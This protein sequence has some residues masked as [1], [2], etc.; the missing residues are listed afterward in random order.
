MTELSP[1]CLDTRLLDEFQRDLPLVPRP[2]AAM[3][4]VLGTTEDDVLERLERLQDCGRISRVGATCRPN[5]AGAS[6][7][8]ALAIPETRIEEVA[9]VVG[10][11][12]GVNHS[13]LREDRWNLWFVA[14]APSEDELSA[15]LA[16]IEAGTGL[17]VLSLP[18]VRPFNI[19]LGFRLRGP[20]QPL[21]L[22]RAPDMKALHEDDRP[23]MQALS[24]G[25]DLVPAPFAALAE[26]LDRNEAE[27]IAR[28]GALAQAR[29][30]TRVGVIVRHRA[31]GWAANAMVV[32]QLP[33][34]AIEAAG[35]A[36]AQVPGVT[37][38]YQ[39]RLVPGVWDWP[40]FCMI[41]ARSREEALE[42]LDRAR[43][44]PELAEVPHKILFSTRCFK[45]RGALIEAA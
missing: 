20:R 8:A 26:R 10:A 1:D 45:Q 36:L 18:L 38:C 13:Y 37:L 33:E 34:P 32:W 12:P 27:V 25:L 23:L 24:K 4:E 43:T 11:E 7:L 17:T 31:L 39:R 6:T 2:F 42:V 5:T 35:R 41:H 29:I 9:A 44:L 3:A 15:S 28:I 22:D 14:T 30:L 16:R 21:G 40:L 19:D